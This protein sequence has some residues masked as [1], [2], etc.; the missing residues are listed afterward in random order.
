[1]I[2]SEFPTFSDSDE[3]ELF[4]I[5]LHETFQPHH[6][7]HIPQQVNEVI[8]FLNLPPSAS[9]PERYFTLN[10]VKHIIQK[11]S[12]NKSLGFDLI[13][14]KVGIGASPKKP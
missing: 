7:I 6:D 10:E 1:M 13:N 5:H 2:T 14:A 11:Y 9:S 12:L 4:K 3:A 8:T